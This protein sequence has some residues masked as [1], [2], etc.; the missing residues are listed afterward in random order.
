ML[1]LALAGL[2]TVA[3]STYCHCSGS[4][5]Y[6]TNG[7]DPCYDFK[8]EH[9]IHSI[10]GMSWEAACVKCGEK[11]IEKMKADGHCPVKV[12]ENHRCDRECFACVKYM[13]SGM[14]MTNPGRVFSSYYEMETQRC[15]RTEKYGR[16]LISSDVQRMINSDRLFR[17]A[18]R[19]GVEPSRSQHMEAVRELCGSEA[20]CGLESALKQGYKDSDECARDCVFR[21]M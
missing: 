17:E 9:K 11:A 15:G 13:F 2:I 18:D 14:Y 3:Q 10:S 16:S 21:L 5:Y 7:N 8:G 20:V 19:F 6:N 4:A 1:F 12:G